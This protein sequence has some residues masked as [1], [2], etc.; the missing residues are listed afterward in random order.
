MIGLYVSTAQRVFARDMMIERYDVMGAT[1][2]RPQSP[3][4]RS[5]SRRRTNMRDMA[6]GLLACTF[7]VLFGIAVYFITGGFQ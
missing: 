6:E 7:I 5:P 3:V 4:A 1:E 2:P